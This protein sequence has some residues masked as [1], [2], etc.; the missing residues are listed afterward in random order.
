VLLALLT[1]L[2]ACR[3]LTPAPALPPLSPSRSIDASLIRP[4]L[5]VSVVVLV[6]GKKEIEELAKPV[7]DKGAI[8]LPL[9]GALTVQDM[10]LDEMRAK[11]T[12]LYRKFFVSPHVIVEFDRSPAAG[13]LSPWGYVTILG[14]VKS[15]GRI[16][17]P[18]THDLTIS[19]V[20]QRAGGFST[21]AKT[22]A[23]LITRRGTD[24]L[25]VSREINFN[26]VGAAGRLEDD[27]PIEA[28]DVIFVPETRF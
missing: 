21:S 9:L 1:L 24:G 3:S 8:D 18:P 5:M 23:I 7:S 4:G 15:P 22:S 11:L 16:G 14:R 26:D 28:D 27:I 13:S 2:S 19:G 25:P 6:G 10:T 12:D 17:I 20:I